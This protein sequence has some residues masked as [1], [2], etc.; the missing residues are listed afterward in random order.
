MQLRPVTRKFDRPSNLLRK[1][2]AGTFA[3]V[4]LF[5]LAACGNPTD[6][7]GSASKGTIQVVTS[8]GQWSALAQQLGGDKVKSQPVINNPN[9]DAHDYEPTTSDIGHIGRADLVIVNGAG[10]DSWASKAANTNEHKIVDIA[11]SSGHKSGDNPHLWF[12][13]QA[14][15]QAAQAI[16]K[17]Y[18]ELLPEE[19]QY[20]SQQHAR[21]QQS[22]Q[23]LS[24]RLAQVKTKVGGS[25]YIATESAAYYLAE[26]IGLT[27]NTPVGFSQAVANESEPSPADIH[28]T[29]QLLLNKKVQLLIFNN[30]EA[31]GV[32]NQLVSAAHTAA[33]PVVQVSEQMPAEYHNLVDWIGSLLT[34]FEKAFDVSNAG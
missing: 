4:L 8:I 19:E 33:L 10:Y 24:N 23:G 32:S 20:F 30:Q 22:E 31:S 29:E 28:S 13:S 2:I 1:S 5:G 15:K 25:T 11:A 26:D 7:K 14:R 27:D 6:T 34:E 21:W 17:A 12:S 3:L 9:A 18:Q 16:T